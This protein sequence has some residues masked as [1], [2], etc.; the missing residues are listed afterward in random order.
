[1]NREEKTALSRQRILDAAMEEFS[2]RGYEG[3]SLSLLCAEKGI[4]KGVIY[5]HFRDRD[6]LYLLCVERCFG[7]VTQYL[8]GIAL[9]FRCSS[10]ERLCSYFDARL[11]FFAEHPLEL[12]VFV[13]ACFNPPEK[14][15][16]EIAARR[17][18]FDALNIAVLTDLLHSAPLR[19]GMRVETVVED[20]RMYM[21]F[22]N[23]RFRA[24]AR[25]GQS[26]QDL[27]AAHEESCHRQMDILLYGVMEDQH[28]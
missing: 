28:E 15:A 20:F 1:M 4:S 21:D 2:L 10:R 7:K 9:E 19:P 14:L 3:A 17:S 12:G 16:A 24:A 18:D 27:L 22:F 25:A 5:H 26:A 8:R 11:R 13:G 6:E 23:L